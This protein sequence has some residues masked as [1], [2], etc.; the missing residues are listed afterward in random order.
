[1]ASRA[2]RQS[3]YEEAARLRATGVSITRIAAEL[4]TERKTVR[5]WLR[6]GHTPSWK[7]PASGSV[8]DPFV[9]MLTRRW[10]EGCR[11]AAQLWREL[12]ALG[13]RGRPSTVRHWVGK[14]RR[15]TGPSPRRLLPF[16]QGKH[17]LVGNLS[18]YLFHQPASYC[19]CRS[20]HRV[21]Q[22]ARMCSKARHGV[23][24]ADQK[25]SGSLSSPAASSGVGVRV[26]AVSGATWR[27]A[28][29]V[30]QCCQSQA[31]ASG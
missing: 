28:C 30:P 29:V 7:Q 4:G 11:N 9:N 21:G 22:A 12:I 23:Q 6:L 20:K 25:L 1:M 3:H 18:G 27:S 15:A 2:R 13:F 24:S 16:L 14:R 19:G 31:R 17:T 10:N 5:R 26:G 8:L